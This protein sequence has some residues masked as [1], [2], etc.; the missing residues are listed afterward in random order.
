MTTT[1]KPLKYYLKDK[2]LNK[3]E[4]NK[5]IKDGLDVGNEIEEFSKIGWR[6]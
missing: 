6:N 2:K 1:T 5:A 3:I 4:K